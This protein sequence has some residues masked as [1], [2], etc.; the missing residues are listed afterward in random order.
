MY[1]SRTKN[2]TNNNKSYVFFVLHLHLFCSHTTDR[3]FPHVTSCQKPDQSAHRVAFG[4]ERQP[5]LG[6]Q[7]SH[8]HR[9][10]GILLL[11]STQAKCCLF[12]DA[13]FYVD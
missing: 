7:S 2:N 1:N 8:C 13:Y 12:V 10:T 5:A 3:P 4:C 6:L 11:V 9:G